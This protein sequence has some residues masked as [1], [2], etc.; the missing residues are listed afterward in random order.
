MLKQVSLRWLT[1][2]AAAIVV[3]LAAAGTAQADPCVVKESGSVPGTVNLPPEGC[4]YLSPSEA[5]MIIDGLAPGTTLIVAPI[6][7]GFL[8][9]DRLGDSVQAGGTDAA[10]GRSTQADLYH[11]GGCTIPPPNPSTPSTE[12]FL[13]SLSFDIRGTGTLSAVHCGLTIR[14]VAVQTVTQ[15]R[16]PGNTVQTFATEMTNLSGSVAN[17]STCNLFS[18][19]TVKAGT[20]QGLANATMGSTTI[21]HLPSGAWQVDSFFDVFYQIDFVGKPGSPLTGLSG[22]TVNIDPILMQASATN[23]PSLSEWGMIVLILM[24]L[25]AGIVLMLRRRAVRSSAVTT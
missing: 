8:C 22:S 7:G 13:S 5:H 10:M 6:H 2:S 4:H 21:T 15:P 17:E 19:L 14:N 24:L 1:L 12:T 11:S 9:N 18:S 16:T 23:I 3:V 20:G 25:T